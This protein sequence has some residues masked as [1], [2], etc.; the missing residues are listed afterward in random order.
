MAR[1]MISDGPFSLVAGVGFEPT[2]SGL[3]VGSRAS[4]RVSSVRSTPPW[5]APPWRDRLTR[6]APDRPVAPGS[7]HRSGHKI[8]GWNRRGLA[9]QCHP[10]DSPGRA[11]PVADLVPW[12]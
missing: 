6:A 2:T 11:R 4:R 7:G 9:C 5:P 1:R 8:R 10:V 3:W 12:V